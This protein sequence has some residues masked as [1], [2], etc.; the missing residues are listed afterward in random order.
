MLTAGGG[1]ADRASPRVFMS[2]AH[3]S[4]EHVEAV[5]DLWVLLRSQGVD[6]RLDLPAAE[7]RQDWALW[8]LDEVR[9]ADFVLVIVSAAYR[10]RAEG[11]GDPDQG[12]G[13]Q[14][15]AALIREQ[16]YADR[17]AGLGKFLPVLLPGA[18]ADDIP[19]FLGP[20][21]TTSYRVAEMTPRGIERLVRVLTGQPWEVQPPLGQI[22][23]LASRAST[24]AI[25]DAMSALE[26]EVVLDVVCEQGRV[27]CRALLAG[28]L[29]GEHQAPMPYG[30]AEVWTALSAAP[31]DA[32][33][34]L[35]D[36]GGRLGRAL[37][38][39]ATAAHLTQLGSVDE[40][41]RRSGPGYVELWEGDRRA[42]DRGPLPGVGW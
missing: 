20:T 37:L 1:G 15:E 5:R 4:L 11:A 14:F 39:D 32:A 41:V 19:M 26:H 3:E 9:A 7:R 8:M 42:R 16:L 25:S 36:A 30:T 23:V 18:S 34:R 6:A 10:R 2:Y 40:L 31:Q 35:A 21:T 38:D 12:R 22:P 24:A 33:A 28:T 13:V 29:L 17:Q 27:R